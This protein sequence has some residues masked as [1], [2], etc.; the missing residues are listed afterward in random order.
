MQYLSGVPTLPMNMGQKPLIDLSTGRPVPA[1][2]DDYRDIPL[3]RE[4]AAPQAYTLQE[5]LSL[6]QPCC[7]GCASGTGCGSGLSGGAS[8]EDINATFRDQAKS[9]PEGT[10]AVAAIG[11][12]WMAVGLAIPVGLGYW[13]GRSKTLQELRK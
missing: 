10:A 6:G 5:K 11:F 9:L 4:A 7:P 2:W 8:A 3:P 12:L 1:A 13:W